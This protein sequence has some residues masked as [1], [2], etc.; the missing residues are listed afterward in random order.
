MMVGRVEANLL[1]FLVRTV[2]AT[3]ILELGTFT[4]KISH[5]WNICTKGYSALAMAEA[6]PTNG[7]LITCEKDKALANIAR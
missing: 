1:Q 4:G 6:L 7:K 5:F 3:K 2:Q